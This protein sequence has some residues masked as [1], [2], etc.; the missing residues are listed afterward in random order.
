ML[1]AAQVPSS[2]VARHRPSSKARGCVRD[3]PADSPRDL[4]PD[5][6]VREH[7]R[8]G[9]FSGAGAAALPEPNG[10]ANLE[11]L[12]SANLVG[13]YLALMDDLYPSTD[14]QQS[15]HLDFPYPDARRDLNRWVPLVK[16]FLALP[17]YVVLFF[18]YVALI[19]VV[20]ISWFAII[21][22]GRYPRGLF[23]FVQG[24]VRWHSRVLGYAYILITDRYPPFSLAE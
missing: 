14:E 20:I 12:R 4:R 7:R 11:L 21:F 2:V 24:V 1:W 19:V 17:H 15:V 18:P 10:F 13:I 5:S 9:P 22:A 8:T 6:G 3:L 23:D 16:W